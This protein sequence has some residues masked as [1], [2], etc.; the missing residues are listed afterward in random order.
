MTDL[1]Q[2]LDAG[3]SSSPPHAIPGGLIANNT[4]SLRTGDALGNG[5]DHLPTQSD[6]LLHAG[7]LSR[8]VVFRVESTS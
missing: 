2:T 6:C 5:K 4:G 8:I 7:T 3:V 1:K